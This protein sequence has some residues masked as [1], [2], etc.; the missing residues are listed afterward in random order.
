[1]ADSISIV[2]KL[3]EDISSNMKTIASTTKG[4]SKEFE[5]MQRKTQ[6]LGQRYVEFNKK[7]AQTQAQAI[8]VKKEMNEAAKAFKK[9]G[10]ESEKIRFEK[11]KEEYDTL[12]DS[13]KAYSNAAKGTMKDIEDTKNAVRKLSVSSPGGGT[14]SGIGSSLRNSGLLKELSGSL[15]GL[16]GVMIESAIGQPMATMASEIVS[17]ALSGAAAGALAGSAILPGI[18]TVAGAGIGAVSGLASGYAQIYKAEDDAFKDYYKSLYETVTQATE[19]GLTNG[20]TL[21]AQRETTKLSFG[22]LLGGDAQ[23]D[24]FLADVLKTANTTPF[25]YDDLVSIS[26]TLLSFGYAVED[27]IPTLTKVGDAGAAMG[28]STADIGTV[29]TYIGRMKSSD[30]AS[31]EYLNP[32]NERGLGVFQWLADDLGISQK[33]VYDKISKGDL[34]GGYVSELILTQFEKLYGGMMEVQ[35]KST[36]GLDSTLQGLMDNIDAAAGDAYNEL[37]NQGKQADI[38]AY[39][40]AL[41]DALSRMNELAGQNQAYTDNMREQYQREALSAVLLGSS[42]TVFSEEQ[43]AQLEELRR[44]FMEASAQY[45]ETGSREAAM[46]MDDLRETAEALATGFF[47][48]SEWYRETKDA[49]LELID[50]IRENTKKLE[51]ATYAYNLSNAFTKGRVSLNFSGGGTPDTW[52]DDGGNL[53]ASEPDA[54]SGWYDD[55]G[56]FHRYAYG[57]KRVPYNGYPALLDANEQ[58]LTAA[59]AREREK[60]GLQVTFSGPITVRQESDLDEIA[61]R[62]ADKIEQARSRAG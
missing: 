9:T 4:A 41:G 1:M 19:E 53:H 38:A 26:K 34:S 49:E 42:T 48:S 17:G 55:G 46:K 58:V 23:A 59:E 40:G 15:S 50:A 29:A 11:L 61:Q 22:T 39:G 47:E 32:L 2:M 35:S 7:A 24:R 33:E 44:Q 52:I 60:G 16:A 10:D 8:S 5:E 6:Q 51:S 3:N 14:A 12:T 43:S 62:L 31:L 13:A 45:D 18:G 54:E 20:K 27:I 56:N 57:L 21:A 25:L 28:L 37:R 36:E 30:K